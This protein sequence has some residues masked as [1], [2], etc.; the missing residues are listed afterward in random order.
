M[1]TPFFDTL[2]DD[3]GIW[4]HTDGQAI[5]RHEGYALDD[6]ARGLLLCLALNRTS[7]AE[8][9]FDYLQKSCR[10][11]GFNGFATEQRQ[12]YQYPASDD[13]TGQVVW[14]MGYA[15]SLG[16]RP[17]QAKAI[18]DGCLDQIT[19][20]GYMRG[21]AYALLG[22]IYTDQD[23]SKRLADKLL[24]LFKDT[25]D[26]WLWPEPVMTY[27]NGII[28]YALI[29]YGSVS[30]NRSFCQFGLRVCDFVQAK[31]ELNQRLLAPIG[32]EGW[33]PK[34]STKVPEY[35]QQPIDAAY[36]IWAWL[37]AYQCSGD[38]KYYQRAKKWQRWFEGD[39]IKHEKMYDPLS[40]KCFDGIDHEGVHYH[41]GAESNI[42]WLLSLALLNKKTTI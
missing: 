35:S 14:A 23:L 10:E 19:T 3:F 17:K 27:G 2:I 20:F 36:M 7:Q 39:N 15:Y 37:A 25:T 30:G 6:A 5:L 13:A 9:L 31:C 42:C 41:S 8:V 38:D 11:D 40:Q 28:P 34:G 1:D 18:I 29:R 22:A 21:D 33:L 32:N 12:F 24:E 26:D 16:F 4:Q